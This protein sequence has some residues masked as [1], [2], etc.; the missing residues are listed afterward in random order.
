MSYSIILQV[1]K[2]IDA[3]AHEKARCRRNDKRIN[4]KATCDFQK[5]SDEQI[6]SY[7][8]EWSLVSKYRGTLRKR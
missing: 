4:D 8:S 6:T 7:P 2:Y 1:D 5:K 3:F